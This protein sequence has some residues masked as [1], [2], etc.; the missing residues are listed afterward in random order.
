MNIM[1]TARAL[2]DNRMT[3]GLFRNGLKTENL[4]M[5]I[6][7]RTIDERKDKRIGNLSP[8]IKLFENVLFTLAHI[9]YFE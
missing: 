7:R 9:K 5:I 8:V 1:P 2:M 3:A 6:D 4:C